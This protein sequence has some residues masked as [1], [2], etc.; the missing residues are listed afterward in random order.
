MPRGRVNRTEAYQKDRIGDF[1]VDDDEVTGCWGV[2]G[3]E[4]GFCYGTF[5]DTPE[6]YKLANNLTDGKA[7]IQ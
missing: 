6:A 1:Y 4:T 5:V 3:S 2:F 7:K